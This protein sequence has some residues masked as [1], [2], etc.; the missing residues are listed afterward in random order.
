MSNKIG[1]GDKVR[2]KKGYCGDGH[3]FIVVSRGISG[4]GEPI[5]YGAGKFGPVRESECELISPMKCDR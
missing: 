2:I 5:L 1:L 4:N 3:R